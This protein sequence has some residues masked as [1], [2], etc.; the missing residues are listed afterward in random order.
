MDPS[1]PDQA[2]DPAAATPSEED[3][4]GAT[5]TGEGAPPP[6][7]DAPQEPPPKRPRRMLT[8]YDVALTVLFI[9]AW[10]IPITYVGATKRDA[11]WLPDWLRHQHR[12]SCL[13]IN[14]VKGW[15]TYRLEVQRGGSDR[16]EPMSEENYFELPVF[17][18]RSRLHRVL[19]H[20]YK[21]GK[22][23]QRLREVGQYVKER[24]DQLNPEGPSLDALRF[25]RIYM[26]NEMLAK[27]TGRFKPMQPNE[28]PA[29]Y[30]LYFGEMR[31]DGK[32]PTHAG[33][34]KTAARTEVKPGPPPAPAKAPSGARAPQ[35]PTRVPLPSSTA[36]RGFGPKPE[37]VAPPASS[38]SSSQD[39]TPSGDL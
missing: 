3:P 36:A 5:G 13:F 7:A 10:L 16:W 14:E 9:L 17:G 32:R 24:Y 26:T 30:V 35:G 18:Y 34:G 31:F 11:P 29:S 20:S 6:P 38:G 2:S 23:A 4:T 27:Q 37:P 28:V 21:K 33:W 1:P 8:V 12:V 19:G 39:E 25:V 22:G 15:Q